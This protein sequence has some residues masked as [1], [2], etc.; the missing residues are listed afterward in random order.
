MSQPFVLT[1]FRSSW[2]QYSDK[3]LVSFVVNNGDD[4]IPISQTV[5]CPAMGLNSVTYALAS[6]NH[7]DQVDQVLRAEWTSIPFI[8]AFQR[9]LAAF[10]TDLA[11][12]PIATTFVFAHGRI[13]AKQRGAIAVPSWIQ[14]GPVCVWA[15]SRQTFDQTAA[16]VRCYH[17]PG[18]CWPARSLQLQA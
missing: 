1:Y 9:V 13:I 16:S 7:A 12:C 3:S 17:W 8:K 5:Y 14:W 11:F 4:L 18:Y 10:A 2:R 6:L 15:K